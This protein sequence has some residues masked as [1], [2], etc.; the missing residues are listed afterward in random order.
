MKICVTGHRNLYGYSLSDIRY[1]FLKLLFKKLLVEKQCDEAFTG[2]AL[3]VD[4]C[5][6]LAVID[7]KDEGYDIKLHCAI[8]CQNHT[9]KW[10]DEESIAT[11]KYILSRADTK[12]IVTDGPYDK[13][14][15]DKR[16]RYMVD[17]IDEVIAVWNGSNSGTK[18]CIDYAYKKNKPVTIIN[19]NEV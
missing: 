3:G 6:A 10:F 12:K 18:N 11:Y 13:Y 14:C 17:L 8:P 5:F 4:M 16:N 1:L 7:L 9:K 15:M 19:P 2:M